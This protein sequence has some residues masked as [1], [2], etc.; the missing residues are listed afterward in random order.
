MTI[1]S[2][3]RTVKVYRQADGVTTRSV[4]SSPRAS[5]DMDRSIHLDATDL[6]AAEESTHFI[7]HCHRGTSR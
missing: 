7:S 4:D 2:V 1:E 3:R 6:Q 5:S